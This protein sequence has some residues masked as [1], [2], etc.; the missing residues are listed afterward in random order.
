[1]KDTERR[2][3]E[4]KET[5]NNLRSEGRKTQESDTQGNRTG[6]KIK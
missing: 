3:V 1:M 2:I 4:K 5:Q 6:G